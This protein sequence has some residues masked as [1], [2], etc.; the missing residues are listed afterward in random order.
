MHECAG[1]AVSAPTPVPP[2]DRALW[3]SLYEHARQLR[4]DELRV[5]VAIAERLAMGR[6]QYGP[7]VI[8]RDSR[9]WRKEASEEALDLSVYLAIDLLRR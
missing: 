2:Q 3:A 7:L 5:L 1:V 9:D 4:G 8:D 6:K